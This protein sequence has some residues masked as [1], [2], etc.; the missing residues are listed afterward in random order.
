LATVAPWRFRMQYRALDALL[1]HKPAL[2]KHLKEKL[3]ES[4][5]LDY[6]LLLYDVT[7]SGSW[8]AAWRAKTTWSSCG[9]ADGATS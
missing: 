1:P 3:G 9:K 5:G 6:D 2:E 7:G 8:I 4:F